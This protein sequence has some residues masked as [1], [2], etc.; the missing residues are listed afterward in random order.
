M[1]SSDITYFGTSEG[2]EYLRQI[3]DATSGIVLDKKMSNLINEELV[4]DTIRLA[5]KRY[6]LLGDCI[7]SN[8][9]K[10]SQ[11]T[12]D[13]VKTFLTSAKPVKL[14]ENRLA[15][16]YDWIESSFANLKIKKLFSGRISK[17]NKKRKKL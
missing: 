11:Y 6:G 3:R 4:V 2:F 12:S 13:L 9:D 10:R 16:D 7:S 14:F 1:L 15:W 17:Q 5:I 8:S